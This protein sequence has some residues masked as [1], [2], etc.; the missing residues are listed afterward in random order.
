KA[1][2]VVDAVENG[3]LAVSAVRVGGYDLVLMDIHMPGMDGIEATRRI[4][5]S[6]GSCADV[7]VIALTANSMKGD[8]EKFLSAGMNDYVAK[9]IDVANFADASSGRPV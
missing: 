8:R 2:H 6:E 3:E 1:G 7:P 4:R 5:Q 9:P